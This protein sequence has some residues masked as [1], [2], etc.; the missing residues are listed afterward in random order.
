[1]ARNGEEDKERTDDER[2]EADD[3][4]QEREGVGEA[5]SR[6]AEQR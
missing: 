2:Q 6:E 4:G 1:M 3:D 5:S